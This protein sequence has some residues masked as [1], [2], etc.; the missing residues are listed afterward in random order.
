MH[1]PCGMRVA[2]PR[3]SLHSRRGMIVTMHIDQF[4]HDMEQIAPSDLVEEYDEGRIGLVVEGT[5][6]IGKVVCALDATPRVV[7]AAV[8]AGADMLVVHHTPLWHP[9]TRIEGRFAK[10]LRLLFSTETNV[11][12]MHSNFDRASG[13]INDALAG[14]LELQNLEHMTM[15]VVGTCS[16]PLEEI[17]R[18]LGSGARVYGELRNPEKLAIVGG[19]GFDPVLIDEAARMG[20][21]A[22]L[23]SELKH[24]VALASPLP[25]IE[26]THYALESP[27]MRQLSMRMGWEFI[28]DPPRMVTCR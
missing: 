9:V 24:S 18:R 12:V 13:G 22:F 23:S 17:V 14:L 8:A 4:I 1:S 28:P 10:L 7:E 3:Q 6:E 25:L 26:S 21:D 20:A 11:Y 27:G 2:N 15:G 16:I 5:R 19:S